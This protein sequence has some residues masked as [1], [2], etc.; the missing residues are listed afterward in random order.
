MKY[1]FGALI[2]ATLLTKTVAA[3]EGPSYADTLSWIQERTNYNFLE[4]SHCNL[5][6]SV[7]DISFD[8]GKLSSV[9]G[10]E[11]DGTSLVTVYCANGSGC[12]KADGENRKQKAI[13]YRSVT[14]PVFAK[15]L[16]HLIVLCGGKKDKA[17]LFK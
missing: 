2:V 8:V 3:E 9:I 13:W 4:T 11:D 5:K 12:I 6:R 17:E 1:F 10:I 16:S 15:A 14:A 7:G